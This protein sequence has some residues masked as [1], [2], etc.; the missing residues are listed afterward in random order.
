[1]EAVWGC[2][3]GLLGLS[4]GLLGGV[5]GGSGGLQELSWGHLG[6]ILGLSRAVWGSCG[7][8]RSFLWSVPKVWYFSGFALG[9]R[10]GRGPVSSCMSY[11]DPCRPNVCPVSSRVVLQCPVSSCVRPVPSCV[12]LL[13]RPS[14]RPPVRS[15]RPPARHTNEVTNEQKHKQ[16][17]DQ[18]RA[19]T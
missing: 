10:L 1:M 8:S 11:F 16:T 13:I 3:G 14:A 4:W 9:G 6:L 5:L 12:V 15:V 7:A 2:F 17:N 18:A 19:R